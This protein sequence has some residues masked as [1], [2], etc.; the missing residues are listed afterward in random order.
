MSVADCAQAGRRDRGS[1]QRIPGRGWVGEEEG[2][3]R[4]AVTGKIAGA[5]WKETMTVAA[6]GREE[7]G[8]R[9]AFRQKVCGLN[10]L[11]PWP[12]S[13]NWKVYIYKSICINI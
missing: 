7:K 13:G 2:G 11:F 3:N 4:Y 12:Q 1:K 5:I 8:R 6:L 10:V 9:R